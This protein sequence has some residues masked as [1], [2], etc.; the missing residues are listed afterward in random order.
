M[1]FSA[2]LQTERSKSPQCAI[3]HS[4]SHLHTF[5]SCDFG[6]FCTFPAPM[7]AVPS[8]CPEGAADHLMEATSNPISKDSPQ[9]FWEEV[10]SFKLQERF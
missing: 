3:D 7:S 2:P 8:W 9:G 1:G 6:L 10:V 4:S 5:N